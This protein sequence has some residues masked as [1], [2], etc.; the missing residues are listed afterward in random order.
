MNEDLGES[1]RGPIFLFDALVGYLPKLR[2]KSSKNS[3]IW[4]GVE[5]FGKKI[6]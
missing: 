2:E 1:F 3:S 4:E 5:E 6:F